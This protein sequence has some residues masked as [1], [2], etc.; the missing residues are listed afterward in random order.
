VT[1]LVDGLVASGHVSREPHPTDRRAVLVTATSLG[2]ATI[3]ELVTGHDDLART[4]FADVPAERLAV[5]VSTLDHTIVTFTRLME[6][7]S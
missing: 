6:D 3:R 4:L 2:E 5:F 1:G 7:A